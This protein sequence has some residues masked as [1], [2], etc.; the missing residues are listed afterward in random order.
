MMMTRRA[1]IFAFAADDDDAPASQI[2]GLF[3]I[4]T[5]GHAGK[6]MAAEREGESAANAANR[7]RP[8]ITALQNMLGTTLRA[9]DS[10]RVQGFV[11]NDD[12]GEAFLNGK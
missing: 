3:G 9:V 4:G 8:T 10:P 7:R 1:E 11:Y 6:I 2:G 5:P 12:T